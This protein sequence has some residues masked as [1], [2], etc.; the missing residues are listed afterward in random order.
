MMK[1]PVYLCEYNN[2]WSESISDDLDADNNFIKNWRNGKTINFNHLTKHK[3]ATECDIE[4]T[5]YNANNADNLVAMDWGTVPW[6]TYVSDSQI[7]LS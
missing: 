5:I 1:I 3:T 2:F 6:I 4:L 7:K